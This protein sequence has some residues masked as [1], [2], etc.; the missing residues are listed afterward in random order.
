M[1]N[2]IYWIMAQ[3]LVVSILING[4]WMFGQWVLY[5]PLHSNDQAQLETWLFLQQMVEVLSY[6]M[7]QVI[8]CEV[9]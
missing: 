4:V 7:F 8:N 1:L 9:C 5:R 2:K 6:D 3:F